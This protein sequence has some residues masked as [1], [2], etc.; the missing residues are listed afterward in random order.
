MA[1]KIVIIGAGEIGNAIQ[2]ILS[3]HKDLD[4][5]LWSRS[6]Q[7]QLADIIPPANFVFLCVPSWAMSEVMTNLKPLL[8]PDT[9]LISLAKGVDSDTGHTMDEL[10][11]DPF[12]L[13]AGPMLA[14]EIMKDLPAAAVIATSDSQIFTSVSQLFAGTLLQVIY[15]PDVHHTALAS[16]LKNVYALGL[17]I[18]EAKKTGDNFKG[19]YICEAVNEMSQL[20]GSAAYSLAGL[21]DLVATGFSSYSTNHQT[22]MEILAGKKPSKPSEGLHS[23]KYVRERFQQ[24]GSVPPLLQS[25]IDAAKV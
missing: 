13:L 24:R 16:I 2:Y 14:E 5:T 15:F 12:A 8:A 17:G 1:T 18:A 6:S 9:V 7:Q 22:G 25:I 23:L 3:G 21:G 4:L 11:R 20:C 19:Q 10:M